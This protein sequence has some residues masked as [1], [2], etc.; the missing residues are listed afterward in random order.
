MV[1]KIYI[2]QY[3]HHE[4]PCRYYWV[5]LSVLCKHVRKNFSQQGHNLWPHPLQFNTWKWR[6]CQGTGV[7]QQ[8]NDSK[9]A[10]A[11]IKVFCSLLAKNCHAK[12]SE[13]ITVV[14]MTG[15]LT[16]GHK[17]FPQFAWHF[18]DSLFTLPLPTIF[19]LQNILSDHIWIWN[20]STAVWPEQNDHSPVFAEYTP[21]YMVWLTFI[22]SGISQR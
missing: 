4:N 13:L 18:Y 20:T 5:L 16:V 21:M 19:T 11:L 7:F 9:R 22:A 2:S 15:E 14:V 1:Y 3:M 8:W 6:P 10:T 17:N 12:G